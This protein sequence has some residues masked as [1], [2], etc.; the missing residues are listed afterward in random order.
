MRD[1]GQKVAL[2]VARELVDYMSAHDLPPGTVLDSE[3]AMIEKYRVSRGSLRES[4]RILEAL[5]IIHMKPGPGG[6]PVV[7]S[8]DGRDFA[9]ITT[10]YYQLEG[11]TYLELIE[12]RLILEPVTA[13]L[14]AQR[15]TTRDCE[16]LQD[17]LQLS[18]TTDVTEDVHFRR[19]GREFHR[20]LA[21]LSGNKL[22][23]LLVDSF[24]NVFEERVDFLYP[25]K[26]R[27]ATVRAHEEIAQAI[28][29]GDQLQAEAL[30]RAHMEHY[31]GHAKRRLAALMAEVV[32]W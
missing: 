25:V 1:R 15:R 10:L 16:M 31:A 8:P 20:L 27:S 32:R 30:M 28:I 18:A 29:D 24:T 21:T 11:A 2:T 6:G 12:A 13:R 5:G 7:D 23:N 9:A 14:A 4:L 17:Y 26:E 19:A 22:I 3:A